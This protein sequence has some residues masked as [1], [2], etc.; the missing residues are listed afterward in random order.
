LEPLKPLE[1][2][3]VGGI[4]PAA[5]R[6]GDERGSPVQGNGSKAEA[7]GAIGEAAFEVV[8]LGAEA[9]LSEEEV[10]VLAEGGAPGVRAR[11]VAAAMR[12]LLGVTHVGI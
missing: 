8:A 12:R 10:M 11:A 2:F 7:I 4:G 5:G 1:P 3:V 6:G 9:G